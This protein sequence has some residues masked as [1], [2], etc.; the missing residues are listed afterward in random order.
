MVT[1]APRPAELEPLCDT[2]GFHR[3]LDGYQP[4]PLVQADAVARDLGLERLLVKNES[5][6]FGLPAFKFLGASWAVAQLLG[7]GTD[8]AQL[9]RAALDAGIG[10]LIAATEGN[11]GQAVARMAGAIGLEAIIY[12]PAA[13]APARRE[14]LLSE[15]ATVIEV[16]GRYDDAVRAA[17]SAARDD[18]S[19]R[20]VNDADLDGSSPVAR[21]VIEG[22][23]TLFAE[24]DEQLGGAVVDVV[25]LQTGVGAFAASG[26]RWAASHGAAAVAVDPAGAACVAASIARARPVTIKTTSTAMAGLDCGTPSVAAWPS[27]WAGLAGAV[28]VSDDEAD[29]AMRTLAAEGIE[30]GES[31]AAG[32]AGLQALLHD[33]ACSPL[34][35]AIDA[36]RT[37]L[38]IVTEGATDPARYASVV[39]E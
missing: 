20:A 6:R 31:G 19:S 28:V 4:T 17:A 1:G 36:P 16:D 15:G 27:L 10:R 8:F 12:V 2:L 11:H 38:V 14:A 7:G 23:S 9:R 21:W 18:P 33:P 3:G 35:R 29:A 34:L 26:V 37:A 22:Y 25:M 13:M 32:L 39:G 30:S 5:N 24:I